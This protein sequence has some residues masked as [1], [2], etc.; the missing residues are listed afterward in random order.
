MSK[1]IEKRAPRPRVRSKAWASEVYEL[2]EKQHPTAG[3]ELRFKNN[4]EL[5]IAVIL[6]AQCTDRRVNKITEVLFKRAPR[7][8]DL[9]EMS[10]PEIEEIIHS[11]GMYKNKAKFIKGSAAMLLSDFGGDVPEKYE[12][13]VTL[14]G[15][16]RKTANVVRSVGF[17]E[18]AI[19]V[20]T[21]VNRVSRRIGLSKGKNVK[22]VEEDLMK[23]FDKSRWNKLHH[24]LIF[25]GR[26]VCS[27]RKPDCEKCLLT[28]YCVAYKTKEF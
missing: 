8:E 14:P 12:D 20:D 28:D 5:L 10:I 9:A 4:Y 7:P 16:S 21:H 27:A 23:L 1:N 17:G 13:L 22:A 11:C 19:A 6:S 25:H 26:Y 15:V 18:P 2:L 3:P 24:L